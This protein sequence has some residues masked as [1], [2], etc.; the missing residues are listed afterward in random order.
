M[1]LVHILCGLD[2]S[3]GVNAEKLKSATMVIRGQIQPAERQEILDEMYRVRKEEE[4]FLEGITGKL[5]VLIFLFFT[6]Q[7]HRVQMAKCL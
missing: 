5:E 6:A 2:P 3:Y 4:K 1:L 7:A